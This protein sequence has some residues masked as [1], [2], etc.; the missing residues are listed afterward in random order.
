M[1]LCFLSFITEQ[2][3]LF[4]LHQNSIHCLR[5]PH[6]LVFASAIS[7]KTHFPLLKP[8]VSKTKYYLW[9]EARELR[10]IPKSIDDSLGVGLVVDATISC[11]SSVPARENTT[12]RPRRTKNFKNQLREKDSKALPFWRL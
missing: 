9:F 2:V 6:N 8:R 10:N 4:H 1:I 12:Y 7:P 5:L 3:V 11:C